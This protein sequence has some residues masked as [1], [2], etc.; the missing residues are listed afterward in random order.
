MSNHPY[1]EENK[2]IETI[3]FMIAVTV[4]GIFVGLAAIIFW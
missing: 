4:V 2:I 3:I 1:P